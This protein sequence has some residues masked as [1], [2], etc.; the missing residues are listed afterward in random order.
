MNLEIKPRTGTYE[1]YQHS[2]TIELSEEL[3]NKIAQIRKKYAEYTQSSLSTKV[4][5]PRETETRVNN[6]FDENDRR[7]PEG[8][9]LRKIT[10][11]YD[12]Y[13]SKLGADY[14]NLGRSSVAG[15]GLR[16]LNSMRD[17]Y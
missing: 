2:S 3:D 6:Y 1:K 12:H 11:D 4:N 5:R 14:S 9:G 10:S 15:L 13:P 16:K 8:L 17:P 7:L